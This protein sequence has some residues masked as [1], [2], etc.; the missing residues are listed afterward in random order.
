MDSTAPTSGAY[1]DHVRKAADRFAPF[2]KKL[3]S[4]AGPAGP[5]TSRGWDRPGPSAIHA[6]R[7]ALIILRDMDLPPDAVI[8]TAKGGI[9]M[10]FTHGPRY[11]SIEFLNS[12]DVVQLTIS[13]SVADAMSVET[14]PTGTRDALRDL[15]LFLGA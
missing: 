12:G 3:D 11:G 9:G 5:W 14:S 1:R 6:A 7:E 13:A 2:D 8:A 4:L 15:R 10:R